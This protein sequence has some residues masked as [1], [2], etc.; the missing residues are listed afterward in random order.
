MSSPTSTPE[1]TAAHVNPDPLLT[2][3]QAAEYTGLS[4]RSMHRLVAQRRIGCVR[5]GGL[6]RLRRS[7]LDELIAQHTTAPDPT[8]P[9]DREADAPAASRRRRAS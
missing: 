5:I 2:Y 6:V 8:P 9:A 3:Q 1:P 7:A 4:S